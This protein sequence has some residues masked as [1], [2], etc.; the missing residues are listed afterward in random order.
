MPTHIVKCVVLSLFF[1]NI[2]KF[3]Q[4]NFAKAMIFAFNGRHTLLSC[5]AYVSN[6]HTVRKNYYGSKPTLIS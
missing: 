6:P 1:L 3:F 4:E 5:I 2:S